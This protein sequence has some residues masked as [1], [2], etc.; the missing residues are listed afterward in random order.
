VNQRGANRGSA[1]KPI[2]SLKT[3]VNINIYSTKNINFI[4][5]FF[6]YDDFSKKLCN[7]FLKNL[8]TYNYVYFITLKNTI[9]FVRPP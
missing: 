6:K 8:Q 1:P 3:Y 2:D 5:F 9:I 4:Y 7:I